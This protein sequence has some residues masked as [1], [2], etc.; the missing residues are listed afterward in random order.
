MASSQMQKEAV[1]EKIATNSCRS[2]GKGSVEARG[3]AMASMKDDGKGKRDSS[4]DE[5]SCVD[6][7]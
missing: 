7:G 2:K 6:N 5:W 4:D 3:A 1:V